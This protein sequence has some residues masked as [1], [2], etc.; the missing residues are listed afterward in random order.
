[1]A[2]HVVGPVDKAANS[3][4]PLFLF[5]AVNCPAERSARWGVWHYHLVTTET[6]DDVNEEETGLN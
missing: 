2:Q 1:M 4:Y 6:T 5:I 3:L